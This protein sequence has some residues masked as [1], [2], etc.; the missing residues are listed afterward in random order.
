MAF[1]L[2]ALGGAGWQFLDS[3]GASLPNGRLYTYAAGTTTPIATYTSAS[4]VTPN[5]NPIILDSAGRPP[6]E[7]WVSSGTIVRFKLTTDVDVEIW[8]KDY[9]P[10]INDA[11]SELG[12]LG[13]TSNVSLGDALVGFRQAGIYDNILI[14]G[15]VGKTV[16]NKL[17]ESVSVRDFGAVG[18]GVTDD[19]SALRAALVYAM[20]TKNINV[21]LGSGKYRLTSTIALT[22]AG[23]GAEMGVTLTGR[24]S[25]SL[26]IKDFDGAMFTFTGIVEGIKFSDF[27]I[28]T[29][30][31]DSGT[32]AERY[33]KC[34][35]M[36]LDGNLNSR[37]DN[38]FCYNALGGMLSGFY[39]CILGKINDNVF[40]NNNIIYARDLGYSFGRGSSVWINGG[41]VIGNYP[42]EIE[43]IGIRFTGDMGGAYIGAVDVI[44]MNQGVLIL[45]LGSGRNREIFL[46]GTIIDSCSNGLFVVDSSYTS[47]N[48]VWAASCN[49]ACIYYSPNVT[50]G[51]LTLTGGTI[52]NAGNLGSGTLGGM[53]G[54]AIEVH[55]KVIVTGV[56]FRNNRGYGILSGNILRTE[57]TEVTGCRFFD[58]G[59]TAIVGS[60]QVFISNQFH[61]KNNTFDGA[62]SPA[63]LV[64]NIRFNQNNNSS[65]SNI[66]GNDGF[67]VSGLTPNADWNPPVIG[68]SVVPVSN[69][70]GRTI[71]GY[72]NKGSALSING[73]ILNGTYIYAGTITNTTV[74]MMPLDTIAV[75]WTGGQAPDAKWY[76]L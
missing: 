12:P 59:E 45:D 41:R 62:S 15:T 50:G 11:A 17:Q 67:G 73:I 76:A 35:F 55:G 7:I 26:L 13:D 68:E 40:F 47:W 14:A 31:V 8:T 25:A 27:N 37:F 21:D 70:T 3:N 1:F 52:F 34:V 28:L 74:I 22:G 54:L 16:H 72:I 9:I 19:T 75:Q 43:G 64:S 42:N 56:Y 46:N 48:N 24:G 38:I 4:G 71:I 39:H 60:A 63:R 36:F 20:T 69:L 30:V 29:I 61:L 66:A 44:Q 58:N 5:P 57:A 32:T 53:S 2:S 6:E 65:Y 10:G 33:N 49:N 51:S 18:D 23:A